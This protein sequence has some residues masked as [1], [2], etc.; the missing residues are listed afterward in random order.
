MK[1]K[2]PARPSIQVSN[3][4]IYKIPYF[5]NR[6]ITFGDSGELV[7]LKESTT[8]DTTVGEK[9]CDS[10]A[11]GSTAVNSLNL[12]ECSKRERDS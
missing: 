11:I 4:R 2:I 12:E 3:I 10:L 1:R 5:P 7:L 8:A 9:Q 6:K